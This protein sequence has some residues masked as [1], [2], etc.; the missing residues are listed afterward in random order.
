MQNKRRKFVC[1]Q[2]SQ[3]EPFIKL[4]DLLHQCLYPSIQIDKQL[5]SGEYFLQEKE[6]RLKAQQERKVCIPPK[7]EAIHIKVAEQIRESNL[8]KIE[9]QLDLC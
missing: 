6:R 4:I 7:N 1:F 5:A 8:F 2:S 3:Q 9:I